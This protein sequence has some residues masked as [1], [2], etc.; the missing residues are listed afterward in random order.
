MAWRRSKSRNRGGS[1]RNRMP[2]IGG[3]AAL[4]GS[5]AYAIRR[6]RNRPAAAE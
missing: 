3:A 4:A 5:A 6:R 1:L 2:M